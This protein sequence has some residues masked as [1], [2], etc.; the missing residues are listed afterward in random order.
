[1][2]LDEALAARF[3]ATPAMAAIEAGFLAA[4]P[5][6]DEP[7]AQVAAL[8]ETAAR[9]GR[10]IELIAVLA[11]ACPEVAWAALPWPPT[12]LAPLHADLCR[13]HTL[14]S[15]RTLCFRL[16]LDD[17]EL[18]G[19]TKSARA[20]ELVLAMNRMGRVMELWHD[21]K[22]EIRDTSWA[23]RRSSLVTRNSSL[24]PLVS[25]ISY[26]VFRILPLVV[27]PA[28]GGA[29]MLALAAMNAHDATVPLARP[30][31]SVTATLAPSPSALSP[32]PLLIDPSPLPPV[33]RLTGYSPLPTASRPTPPLLIVGPRGANLRR[34]PSAGF[35]VVA[36]LRAG[37]R[38]E[39]LA[40]SPTGEWYQ[41]RYPGHGSPWIDAGF[42]EIIGGAGGVPVST[43]SAVSATVGAT[44]AVPAPSL[45]SPR[46]APAG[47]IP[48]ASATPPPTPSP[49]PTRTAPPPLSL[50]TLPPP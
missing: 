36:T 18:P 19:E 42:A 41:V 3:R 11:A 20:R 43:Y 21:T 5:I 38:L 6:P 37:A 8:V 35:A 39:L 44:A 49:W 48:P 30:A 40:V 29:A 1:M 45:A 33:S 17:D 32:V 14:D 34:G 10:A 2:R 46:G 13:R 9:D 47:P 50:P 24:H 28:V 4:N 22:D 12:A 26:L 31:S 25:R 23:A 7:E 16:G 27:V 15:L